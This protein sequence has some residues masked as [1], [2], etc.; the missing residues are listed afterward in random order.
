MMT[1]PSSWEPKLVSPL[2]IGT[3]M[4]P[5]MPQ[6]RCTGMAPTTSSILM[7]SSIGTAK[8]TITPPTAP[9]RVAMPRR[10][11]SAARR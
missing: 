2:V 5:Q 4:V 7:R 11:A 8:T 9:M 10:R 3:A 6:S 1:M